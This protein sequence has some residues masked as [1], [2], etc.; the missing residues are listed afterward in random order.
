MLD[1]VRR[2]LLHMNAGERF[3]LVIAIHASCV[4]G[5]VAATMGNANF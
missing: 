2:L 5:K 1:V 3:V 4:I